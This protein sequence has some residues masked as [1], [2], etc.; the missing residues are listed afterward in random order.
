MRVLRLIGPTAGTL[1]IIL[2][3]VPTPVVTTAAGGSIG[4]VV[5]VVSPSR[6]TS[7]DGRSLP[8]PFSQSPG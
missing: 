4:G 1:A 2:C 7:G 5:D 8:G 6:P 3:V